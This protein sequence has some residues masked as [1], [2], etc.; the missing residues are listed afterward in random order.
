MKSFQLLLLCFV[1]VAKSYGQGGRIVM[2]ITKG[3]HK[4]Y[5]TKVVQ[6]NVPRVDSAW[7]RSFENKFNQFKPIKNHVKKG[8]YTVAIGF[9]VAKDGS[10]CD[11]ECG[12]DPGFGLGAELVRELKR[13]GKWGPGKVI[14][15]Q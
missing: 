8:T 10:F 6:M 12:Y 2:A 4:T 7:R 9:I 13:S 5:T 15:R 11:I 14:I 1:F 3:S